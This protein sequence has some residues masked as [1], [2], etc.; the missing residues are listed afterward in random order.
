MKIIDFI[1]EQ[2]AIWRFKKSLR[3]FT[4]P[5][6]AFLKSARTR[7]VNLAQQSRFGQNAHSDAKSRILDSD[8]AESGRASRSNSWKYAT[9][10]IVAVF[11]MT[12]GMAVFADANNVP[13]T[14]PLYNFKRLSEQVRLGLSSPVQQVE[15]HQAFAHRR[16][17]EVAE[18]EANHG[19]PPVA[20]DTSV[21]DRPVPD[22]SQVRIDELNK[23]FQNE[24]ETV[25]DQI[26]PPKA[27]PE[28]RAKFC[29]DILD[30]I[31]NRPK[32]NRPP[33]PMVDHI[34]DRCREVSED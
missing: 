14:H 31:Q 30:T 5:D 7:F 29:N 12:S 25:L 28:D 10:A 34:K 15:L 32:H 33:S 16:L 27:Q 2:L 18:L 9:I 22:K 8:K 24:T 21:S 3:E 20:S 26:N 11:S 13:A 23:D 6:P 1:K 19:D 17:E 4:K